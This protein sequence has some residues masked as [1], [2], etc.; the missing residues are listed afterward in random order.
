MR[1]IKR[2]FIF[3]IVLVILGLIGLSLYEK[4][5]LDFIFDPPQEI[6][7]DTLWEYDG[8]VEIEVEDRDNQEAINKGQV[9]GGMSARYYV[10]NVREGNSINT[11]CDKILC[12][13]GKMY[14]KH[15]SASDYNEKDEVIAY[16]IGEV[17]I[18]TYEGKEASMRNF[19]TEAYVKDNV[20]YVTEKKGFDVGT[21]YFTYAFKPVE[22]AE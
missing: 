8:L 22:Q 19:F 12:K 13:D 9:Y 7:N 3:A 2:I 11:Y 4:G 20:L 6:E 14:L 18:G 21:Y 5:K 16:K 10:L 15:Y 17:E 1:I